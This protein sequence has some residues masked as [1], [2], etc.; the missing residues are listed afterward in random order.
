MSYDI[1]MRGHGGTPAV[2]TK[3][4]AGPPFIVTLPLDKTSADSTADLGR[5]QVTGCV[6]GHNMSPFEWTCTG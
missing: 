1:V 4:A 2:E 5:P 6:P 3:A